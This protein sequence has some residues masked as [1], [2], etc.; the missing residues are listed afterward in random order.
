MRGCGG[1][2]VDCCGDAGLDDVARPRVR[3]DTQRSVQFG[4]FLD[5]G[6]VSADAMLVHAGR[7]TG[8]RVAGR[9]VLAIQDTTKLHFANHTA[10]KRGF[11][12]G[13]NGVDLGS[14]LHPVIAIDAAHNGVIG[15]AG[16]EVIH[17]WGQGPRPQ[18]A[19]S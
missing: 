3:R 17:R 15:L 2:A 5:N 7:H 11:G 16:A 18:A 8:S 19:R 4:R 14:F 13:G 1:L 6:A 9:H 10:S 12:A